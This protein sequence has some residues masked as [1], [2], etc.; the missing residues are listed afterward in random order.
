MLEVDE[1]SRLGRELLRG[2]TRYH[3]Y[4]VP[5]EEAM[6]DFYLA[7]CARLES[8]GIAQYEISNFARESFESRHNLKYW[9]RQPYFGFG[10]DAHSMLASASPE[11]EA[12]RFAPYDSLEQYMSGPP[13]QRTTVS[14]RAAFEESCFLGLRLTRGVRLGELSTKFGE[15]AVENARAAIAEFVQSGLME[16]RGDFVLLTSRWRLLSNEVF[17]RVVLVDEIVH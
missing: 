13:L 11:N 15:E 17:E 4:F 7:G 2:G 9:T 3:A 14:Q 12:V 6:A 16:Q 8:A 1:G 10:V 5:D